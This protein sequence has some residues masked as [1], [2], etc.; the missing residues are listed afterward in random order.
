LNKKLDDI[1]KFLEPPALSRLN[2][3]G[4]LSLNGGGSNATTPRIQDPSD[5]ASSHH[6]SLSSVQSTLE[7]SQSF[8][9]P[10]KDQ[11][12]KKIL[13]EIEYLKFRF[14]KMSNDIS[15]LKSRKAETKNRSESEDSSYNRM[16][17]RDSPRRAQENESMRNRLSVEAPSPPR[18]SEQ[19][20]GTNQAQDIQKWAL[21][22]QGDSPLVQRTS[23]DPTKPVKRQSPT[24]YG[25]SPSRDKSQKSQ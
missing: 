9:S 14:S 12:M 20:Q 11:Q 1:L 17:E 8:S 25:V 16:E 4:R 18:G 21:S 22:R 23:G 15:I 24:S 3:S 2:S 7:L 5:Q 19:R 10:N 13:S 6:A